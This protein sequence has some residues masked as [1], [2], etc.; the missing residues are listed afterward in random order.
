MK[1]SS[2]QWL[3]LSTF[4]EMYFASTGQKFMTTSL[5][6]VVVAGAGKADRKY[7]IKASHLESAGSSIG[8]TLNASS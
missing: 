4:K 8:T 2:W 7:P 1:A 5:E 3:M 6:K